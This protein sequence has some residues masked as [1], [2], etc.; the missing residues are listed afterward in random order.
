MVNVSTKDERTI[1]RNKPFFKKI[2]QSQRRDLNE[3]E[4]EEDDKNMNSSD[5]VYENT[6]Q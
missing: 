2:P 3:E 1:C 4:A 6:V 5:D